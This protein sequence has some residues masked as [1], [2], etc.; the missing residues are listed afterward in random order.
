MT[1]LLGVPTRQARETQLQQ[2]SPVSAARLFQMLATHGF[3]RA[4]L[5]ILP[6]YR[7]TELMLTCSKLQ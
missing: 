1:A 7:K 5:S 3:L 2:R 4:V 6:I